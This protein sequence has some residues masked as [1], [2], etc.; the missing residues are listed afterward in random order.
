MARQKSEIFLT[1]I[2][3]IR[4]FLRLLGRGKQK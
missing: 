2:A 3:T 4:K 1:N